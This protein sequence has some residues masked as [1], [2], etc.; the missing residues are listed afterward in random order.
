MP[1]MIGITLY[2]GSRKDASGRFIIRAGLGQR[3]LA[4]SSLVYG[5]FA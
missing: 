4:R 3:R 1:V 5:E 2:C